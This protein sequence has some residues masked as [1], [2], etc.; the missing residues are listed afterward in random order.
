[1]LASPTLVMDN[2]QVARLIFISLL[3]IKY[4]I[5]EEQFANDSKLYHYKVCCETAKL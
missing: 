1:M 5:I 3:I 2:I 4:M